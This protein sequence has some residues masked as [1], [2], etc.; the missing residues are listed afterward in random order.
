MT[1]NINIGQPDKL[2]NNVLVRYSAFV[3]CDYDSGVVSYLKALPTRV[4]HPTRKAWEMPFTAVSDMANK[5]TEHEFIIEGIYH[6]ECAEILAEIPDGFKFKTNPYGYQTDGVRY[7]LTKNKFL[8]GDQMGL[9]KSKQII[10]WACCL[11]QEGKIKRALIICGVNSLKYNW[12]NEIATHSTESA[13]VIGTRYRKNGNPYE[14]SRKDK[15][16]DLDNLPEASFLITN[17]ETLRSGAYK[18]GN[19]HRYPFADKINELVKA[20]EISLI[21]LD[22]AHTCFEYSTK[23]STDKGL[24]AIGDIVENNIN[25]NVLC[26]NEQSAQIE[27]KPVVSWFKNHTQDKNFV[28]LT[29]DSGET[30]TCTDDHEFFTKNRGWVMAKNLTEKDDLVSSNYLS[31]M[32]RL[33]KRVK[34]D[35]MPIAYDIEVKDNHNYF[36]NGVLVHNCKNPSSQQ[37]R[38]M[39]KTSAPYMVAMTGTPIMN[40]PLDLFVPLSW[41]GY[42][43]HTYYAF[44]NHYC[45]MGGYGG[46]EVVGYKNLHEIRELLDVMMLRRL[47]DDVL[48][49]PEKIHTDDIVDM[50]PKQAV[51]YKEVLNQV[52][53]DLHK[54]SFS[55]NPLAMLIKLRQATGYTGIISDKIAESAKLDRLEEIV[56]ELAENGQKCIVFSNWEMITSVVVD[57]LKKYSPA[58]ITGKVKSDDRMKEVN[59][60][61]NDDNCKV[62]IGTMGA[63]GTGLTLTAAQTVI[64]LDEPWT[65][66]VKSQCEDRCHRIGT[67]GSVQVI[68]LMCRNTIDHRINDIVYK[69]GVLSDMLIDGKG[70]KL[71][72]KIL[73]ELLS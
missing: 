57:R 25:C 29:F 8:L 33:V 52:K 59:R 44:K 51:I 21:A 3:T 28:E 30:I 36:A 47:K 2:A 42:D 67:K 4:Y 55:D 13:W 62:I 38:A 65:Q 49:L 18:E 48:D 54:I 43:N 6:E 66:A 46:Q 73:N 17:I 39:L 16:A 70:G 61:Q 41:L 58:Y 69:K 45:N 9:G 22:E 53:S 20:G 31:H 23:I 15:L 12:K 1:I 40:K 34:V 14:G 68:T 63:M 35:N 24:L 37:G 71:D 5:F 60:F 32:M 10:D 64:F 11:K 56:A 26:Y 19:R 27:K 7:A 72:M 50:T